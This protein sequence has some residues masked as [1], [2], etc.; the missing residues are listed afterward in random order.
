MRRTIS[1]LALAVVCVPLALAG[2]DKGEGDLSEDGAADGTSSGDGDEDAEETG[3]ETGE[4]I[5]EGC[6]VD[7]PYQGGWDIGCCQDDVVQGGG[8]APGMVQAGTILPDW[9]FTD[10]YGDSVRLYDFCHEA[11][12][13]EYAA[14]WCGACMAHAPEVASLFNT[15]DSWGLM[16]L[17]Y[18]SENVDGGPAT[19]A[20]VQ[21][22]SDTFSQDGLVVFSSHEDVWYP[23]G[24]DQGGG[25]FGISLPSTI[26]VGPDMKI[27]KMGI[28]TQQEIELVSPNKP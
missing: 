11:I 26:F 21:A 28:P 14:M 16:T 7:S 2:C 9:T 3:G 1:S 10:Q 18:M 13:F 6:N 27:A 8:W 4:P 17:T 20:D 25:S 24:V 22:W 15:Y 12:Y 19:L 5:E 23:F